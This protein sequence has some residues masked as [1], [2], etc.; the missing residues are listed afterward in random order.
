MTGFDKRIT[1]ARP[2]LAAAHLKGQVEAARFAGGRLLRVAEEV[3][4]VRPEPNPEAS[5][6]TQALFGEDVM[7]YEDHEGWA[8][9]Q[10]LRDGYVG[11]FPANALRP[12]GPAATHRVAVPRSFAWPGAS[13]KLPVVTALPLGARLA[14]ASTQG[15]FGRLADGSFVLLR[16]LAALDAP[17]TDFAGVAEQFLHVPYLWGGKTSLGLDCSG[18]VQMSLDAAGIAAPRD[19]DMLVAAIGQPVEI[20]EDFAGLARGDLMF[21]RGHCGIMQDSATLL[22]ANGH[23][24][25]VVSEPLQAAA[26][27]LL[28]KSYGAVTAIRRIAGR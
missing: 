2:D 16:H 3:I 6:D 20:T 7:V 1:P 4:D 15:E 12:P 5:L 11:Y 10:L 13:I 24:M 17:A 28:A 8:W 27:R 22:H 23:H 19:S 26:A 25:Q 9:G 18:L 14:L 21:W